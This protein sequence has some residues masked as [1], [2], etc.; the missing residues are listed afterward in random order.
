MVGDGGEKGETG[1]MHR[2][3]HRHGRHG[4][5]SK[6]MVSSREKKDNDKVCILSLSLSLFSPSF[7]QHNPV[8]MSVA[9]VSRPHSHCFPLSLD[10]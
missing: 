7:G 3:I 6:E 10:V 1:G 5:S 2:G 9:S 4:E 8:L